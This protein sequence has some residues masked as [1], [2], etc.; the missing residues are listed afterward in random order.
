MAFL[1]LVGIVALVMGG[2]YAASR[3]GHRRDRFGDLQVPFRPEA[4]DVRSIE[5]G[6]GSLRGRPAL[7]DLAGEHAAAERA[8]RLVLARGEDRSP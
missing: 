7:S 6:P 4:L 3:V 2:L 5:R 8:L 1:L